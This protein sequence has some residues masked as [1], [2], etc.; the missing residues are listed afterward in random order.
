MVKSKLKHMREEVGLSQ[1]QLSDAAGVPI[2]TLQ[3]YEQGRL[4]IDQ[5]SFE[6]IIRIAIALGCKV[7]DILSGDDVVEIVRRY[8]SSV[9][10][11]F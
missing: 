3:N 5:C 7:E 1:L 11:S 9:D 2:R 8:R 10:D 4:D 6:R